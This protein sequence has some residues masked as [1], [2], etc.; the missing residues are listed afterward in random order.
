MAN[1]KDSPHFDIHDDYYTPKEAWDKIKHLIPAD[2]RVWEAFLLNSHLSK[3]VAN[4]RE[5]N[6]DAFG[7]VNH[8]FLTDP[9]PEHD[10]I[11]SNPPFDKKIKIP[12]LKKLVENDKPFIIIMNSCNIYTNYFNDTFKD[13]RQ[14]LQIINPKGKI[15]FEKLENGKT[16]LKKGCSFY[17]VYI[18]Y[19]MNLK[20][21]QLFLD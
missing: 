21:E 7:D 11:V 15:N 5:L 19:K 6:K 4:L 1:F 13:V 9:A 12:I 20:P 2:V 8:N 16:E 3:S 17:S 10:M 14:H 18:A